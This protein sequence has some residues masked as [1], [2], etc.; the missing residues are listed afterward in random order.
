[1][2]NLA[3]FLLV[4]SLFL[5]HNSA[6][7]SLAESSELEDR[8]LNGSAGYARALE[9]QRELNVP[10][11]VYFYADWC[12]YCHTLDGR[13]LPSAPVQD[14]LRRVVKVR[15][16]PEHGR[17]ESELA[18]RYGVTGYPTF[19]VIRTASARPIEIS[20]FRQGG[21]NLTPAEFA[22]ACRQAGPVSRSPLTESSSGSSR[23]LRVNG[24]TRQNGGAQIVE[25]AP[26]AAAAPVFIEDTQLP[27][28]DQVLAKYVDAIGGKAAQMRLTSRVATGRV[29]LIG[30]S[31]GGRLQSYA[32]APNKSL[33]VMELDSVGVM[34]KGFDG[35]NGWEQ[36]DQSGL[37]ASTGVNLASLARDAEFYHDL[38]L[39][40][41]FV[42]TRLLGKVKHGFREVYLVEA[43]PRVG[44][45]EKLY[46]DT[47][48]G[49]L[50][51]RDVTRQTSQGP[52]L[53]EIYLSDWRSVDGVKI[54]FK[55]T[56]VMPNQTFVF[57]LQEVKHNVPV[58]ETI[59]QK[60]AK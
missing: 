28:L 6:T 9:L 3:R 30:I 5:V 1:M 54:P 13:Y 11:V 50:V 10:L 44:T 53:A 4:I 2:K 39:K 51:Q 45:P 46:F 23:A 18:S 35:R 57:T 52:V 16:N 55:T 59:F 24:V 7:L 21:A 26:T 20:P 15:I 41:L 8:W 22:N 32:I 40:E 37:R 27:T 25:V 49:L 38:K 48:S 34:R 43:T 14:Y 31:N 29:D 58:D 12:P 36:S 47:Q 42:R 19:L 60:P 33:L 17:P 56:Q